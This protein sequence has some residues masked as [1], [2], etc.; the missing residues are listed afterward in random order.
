MK[1]KS[2]CQATELT[3]RTVRYY[4]EEGLIS[5]SY[6]EN[7]LGRKS[8]DFSEEDISRLKEI[9]L[10]RKFDFTVEEIK[11]LI[12]QTRSA[13]CII[14]DIRERTKAAVKDK[15]KI[16]S[17]LS[18]ISCDRDYTISRLA[19]ELG[20]TSTALPANEE[21]IKR[22]IPKTIFRAF[23]TA[24]RAIIVW[25]PIVIVLLMLVLKGSSY[26]YPKIEVKALIFTLISLLPS[27]AVLILSRTKLKAKRMITVILLILCILC[28]PCNFLC[29]V[30]TFTQ[31][32]TADIRNYRSFDAHCLANR[33]KEFQELFPTRPHYFENVQQPDGSYETVYLDARYY[34][35]YLRVMDYTYDI[36]AQWPL[37]A[38]EY[39]KEVSRVKALYEG[40]EH[41][42][43]K[44]GGYTC[45][46]VYDGDEP[47]EEA[48]DNYY[49][50]IFAY[51]D[52]S[53]TVRYICCSSFENGADQP[54]YLKLDW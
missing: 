36:Y 9:A 27:F 16:L 1:I 34:Y 24:V 46:V 5:P 28:I 42:T 6:T 19:Q 30:F 13:A 29:S 49:Y 21:K 41:I 37:P 38:D 23:I 35:R 53:K 4:I 3:D 17:A 18:H 22:N 45:M 39:E 26:Y 11:S 10:L 25:L 15:E 47:F 20:R 31:S 51:N 33:D 14:E 12:H 43:V 7:Y 52:Q 48:S 40:Y 8:Y 2:V 54:Y 50:L 44:K 32:V